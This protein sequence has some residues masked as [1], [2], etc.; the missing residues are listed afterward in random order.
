M[1]FEISDHDEEAL[2]NVDEKVSSLNESRQKCF[3][4][5]GIILT[6]WHPKVVKSVNDFL[7]DDQCKQFFSRN[8]TCCVLLK[9]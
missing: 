8:F 1:W 5:N 3:D 4:N 2:F 7:K 6:L 9:K